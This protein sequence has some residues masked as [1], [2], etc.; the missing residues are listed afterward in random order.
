MSKTRTNKTEY[1]SPETVAER[2]K[3]CDADVVAEKTFAIEVNGEL[4]RV[5]VDRFKLVD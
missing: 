2:C 4:R 3:H 1:L 5:K